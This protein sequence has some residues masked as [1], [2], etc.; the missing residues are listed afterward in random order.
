MSSRISTIVF[1]TLLLPASAPAEGPKPEVAGA[2]GK[3]AFDDLAGYYADQKKLPPFA[4]A[5]DD[6]RGDDAAARAKA[7]KYLL[8]LFKQ[9][10]ADEDNGRAPWKKTPYFGGGSVNAAREF[11]QQLAE[12]FGKKAAGADAIESTIWLLDVERVADNQKAGM[13]ALSRLQGPKGDAVVKHLLDPIHPNGDVA[14]GAVK[15]V[16]KRKL[17]ELGPILLTLCGHYRESVRD[18]ARKV[19]KEMKLTPIP[20]YKPDKAFTPWLE[21]Q[22]TNIAAMAVIDIP[23]DAKWVRLKH[24]ADKEDDSSEATGWLLSEEGKEYRLL[25]WFGEEVTFPKKGTKVTPAT[26]AET[27]EKFRSL[28]ANTKDRGQ[29]MDILSRRGPASG[30]FQPWFVSQPELLVGAWAFVR[31]DRKT[32]AAA[33]FERIDQMQDDRWLTEVARDLIGH[34]YHQDMLEAFSYER[35]YARALTLAKHLSKPLFNDY[36]YQ[37]RAKNLAEQLP[38]RGED[39]KTF[40][41][42]TPAEWKEQQAKLNRKEQIKYLADRLRLVNCRQHGQPGGVSYRD[43]QRAAT[44]ADEKRGKI[45]EVINPY[46][47]L[48]ALKLTVADLPELVPY[49]GD[50]NYMLV[51]SYWRD[52]HPNRTLHQVNWAVANLVNDTAKRDLADLPAYNDHDAAGR[53]AHLDKILAWCKANANKTREQLLL[54]ALA[55]GDGEDFANAAGELVADK[56]AKALPILIARMKDFKDAQG[57]IVEWCHDL[58]SAEAAKPAREWVQSKDVKTRFWA[59]LILLRHG[60]KK[61]SEGLEPLRDILGKDDGTHYYPRALDDLLAA[62]T[63]E[64]LDLAAGIIERPH[65]GSDHNIGPVLHRLLLAGR[66][67]ALDYLLARLDNTESAGTSSGKYKGKE[68]ERKQIVADNIAGEIAGWRTDKWEYESLAPAKER[69]AQR[70]MLKTWLKEQFAL[71]KAGKAPMMKTKPYKLHYPEYRVDAP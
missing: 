29:L 38:R 11:R 37:K 16:G 50:D 10:L 39:F 64:A 41:L 45:A 18:E 14:T 67:E 7:G 3:R 54:D 69:K 49:L 63:K 43:K 47:E 5:L 12:A 24:T 48:F 60:D 59:A 1:C 32:A 55:T 31:G 71:I 40:K 26:L 35:D 6:L 70:E 44:F 15:E 8:A 34:T 17:K 21:K 62:K 2:E 30:Q 36:Q 23:K 52:F 27:A 28:R 56:N 33:L 66:Q 4:A 19:A 25:D 65:F 57:E 61:K 68:V 46:T 13:Q 20:K 58:D 51:F 53:K 9:S 42:P 22:L